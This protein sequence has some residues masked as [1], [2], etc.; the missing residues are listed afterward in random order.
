[1]IC[2]SCTAGTHCH[3][4]GCFCQHLPRGTGRQAAPAPLSVASSPAPVSVG[5]HA[6]AG[7]PAGRTADP[8]H[9]GVRGVLRD[10]ST[11]ELV[12]DW[13]EAKRRGAKAR[14]SMVGA[15]LAERFGGSR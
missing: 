2:P 9:S 15:V 11:V 8:D 12:A 1:M 6:P 4:P 13:M 3:D 5:H 14:E 7:A 10:V